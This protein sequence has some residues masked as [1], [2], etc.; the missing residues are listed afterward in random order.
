METIC[1]NIIC[2]LQQMQEILPFVTRFDR[3]VGVLH[4]QYVLIVW[5]RLVKLVTATT[6]R[7]C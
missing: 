4:F 7:A 1:F 3:H 2:R 5:L 6:V